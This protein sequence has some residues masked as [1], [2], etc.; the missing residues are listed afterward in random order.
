M[1]FVSTEHGFDYVNEGG[2][3]PA[4]YETISSE[5]INTNCEM[6]KF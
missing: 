4:F 3:F 1:G 2:G 6:P 5:V